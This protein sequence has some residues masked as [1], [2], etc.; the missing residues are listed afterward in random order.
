MRLSVLVELFA[1]AMKAWRFSLSLW[2]YRQWTRL[3][4]G[5]AP[6]GG[7]VFD[8]RLSL[9]SHSPLPRLASGDLF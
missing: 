5:L 2:K 7:Q 4:H 8:M 1:S 6:G 9:P 3:F